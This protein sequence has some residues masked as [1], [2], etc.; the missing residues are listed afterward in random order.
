MRIQIYI[1]SFHCL[2]SRKDLR[3]FV[4]V[5]L[6]NLH[7]TVDQIL[8]QNP[9]YCFC[10]A[11]PWPTHLNF[12]HHS[13]PKRKICQASVSLTL[14]TWFSSSLFYAFLGPTTIGGKEERAWEQGSG[15]DALSTVYVFYDLLRPA[16]CFMRW[17]S[18]KV[19]GDVIHAWIAT[20][21]N[22]RGIK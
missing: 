2:I 14:S 11:L 9:V 12:F 16:T 1:R 5:F 8:Y 10:Y 21:R 3:C 15:C 18:E 6:L 7:L 22:A 20:N 17:R 19:N 13:L 4:F